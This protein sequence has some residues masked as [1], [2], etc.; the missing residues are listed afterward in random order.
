MD[1]Q[2]GWRLDAALVHCIIW[3]IELFILVSYFAYSEKAEP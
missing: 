2:K 3:N 1:Q